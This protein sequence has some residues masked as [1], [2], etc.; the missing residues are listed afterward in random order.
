MADAQTGPETPTVRTRR[1]L[2]TTFAAAMHA[3]V[4][5]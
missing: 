4:T 2:K 5:A 1:R 3:V